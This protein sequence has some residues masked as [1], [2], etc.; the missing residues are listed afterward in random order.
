MERLQNLLP[1][2]NLVKAFNSVGSAFMYKP[3]FAG[4]KPT[5]F[6]CGNDN[7]AKKTVTDILD[8][9]GWETEDMGNANAAGPIEALCILWCIPGFIRNDWALLKK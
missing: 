9:F 3:D 4:I 2:A 7:L 1:K 5:M 6:I 8:A